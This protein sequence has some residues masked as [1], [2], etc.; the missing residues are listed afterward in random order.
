LDT[1]IG[2]AEQTRAGT[3]GGIREVAAVR[4]AARRG[5][6]RLVAEIGAWDQVGRNDSVPTTLFVRMETLARSNGQIAA[7]EQVKDVGG[8]VRHVEGAWGEVNRLQRIHTSGTQEQFAD[9]RPSVQVPAPRPSPERSSPSARAK[10]PVRSAC[11]EPSAI[12]T[13]AS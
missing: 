13:S 5:N 11:T 7:L 6:W 12:R 9:A 4:R 8:G 3:A 10:R 1:K 2:I